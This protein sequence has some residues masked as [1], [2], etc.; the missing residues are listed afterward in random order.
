ML[1]RK[2]FIILASIL[3]AWLLVSGYLMFAEPEYQAEAYLLPPQQQNIQELLIDYRGIEGI[4]VD[5]YTPESVYESFLENLRSQGLRRKFFDSHNL[6]K[7]YTDGK[8]DED[9]NLDHLFKE[10]FDDRLKVHVDTENTS[11]VTVQFSD[12]DPQLAARWLNQLIEQANRKTISE[13]S[14]DVNAA[15]QSE[16]GKTRFQLDSKLKL[17]ER[18]RKDRITILKEAFRVAQALGIHDPGAYYE[19]EGKPSSELVINTA[20][21]P[22]YMRGT[23]ALAEEI[24]VLEK[25]TSD[26]PFIEGFRDLEERKAFLEGISLNADLLSAVTIDASAKVPARAERPRKLLL[27]SIA[28]ML[29]LLVGIF[30]VFLAEFRSKICRDGGRV[31][32]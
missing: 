31:S 4:D 12:R 11:F 29:G 27:V 13:L 19:R 28:T 5:R 17:A 23:K 24:S 8:P 9:I 16:I 32:A 7:H 18:R 20:D 26:E 21:V 10:K 2:K 3:L 30:L 14:N 1:A 6:L 15:I 25:R 22:T